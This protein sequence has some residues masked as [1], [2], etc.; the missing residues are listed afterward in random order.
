MKGKVGCVDYDR[1]SGTVKSVISL[2]RT[3]NAIYNASQ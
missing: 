1:M 2:V 3:C